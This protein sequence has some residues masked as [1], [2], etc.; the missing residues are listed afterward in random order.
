[1]NKVTRNVVGCGALAVAAAGTALYFGTNRNETT[2]V[3]QEEITVDPLQEQLMEA[4]RNGDNEKRDQILQQMNEGPV[5][6][7]K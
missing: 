5:Q 7:M 2:P 6:P 3:Q 4:V 1:M